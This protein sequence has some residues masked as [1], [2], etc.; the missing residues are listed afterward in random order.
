MPVLACL[1]ILLSMCDEIW[2]GSPYSA[3]SSA[4]DVAMVQ[5]FCFLKKLPWWSWPQNGGGQKD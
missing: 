5:A 3:G 1:A 4:S 2:H